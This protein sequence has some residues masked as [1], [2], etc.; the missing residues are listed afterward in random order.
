MIEKFTFDIE[1]PFYGFLSRLAHENQKATG[2]KRFKKKM[3]LVKNDFELRSHVVLKLLSFMLYYDS[4]LQI[5]V[6]VDMHYKP[7]L[8]I[9]GDHGVPEVWID[10]GHVAPKKV[11]SLSGK[12]KSARL[13]VV[14][15]NQREMNEFRKLMDK[16]LDHPERIEYLSFDKGF[17]SGLAESLQRSNEVTLYQVMENV[18]GVV[19]NQQVFES[20][21]HP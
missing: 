15:E 8:V 7:D 12:L 1:M 9:V 10:C 19:L 4:R 17:V 16:K 13:C 5:E 3:I 20:A 6:S 14:K 11:E 21:L 2:S 18:I